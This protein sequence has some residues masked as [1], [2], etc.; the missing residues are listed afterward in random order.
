MTDYNDRILQDWMHF[1]LLPFIFVETRRGCIWGTYS[2][3]CSG[4]DSLS[5]YLTIILIVALPLVSQGYFFCPLH[6]SIMAPLMRKY[7]SSFFE[8]AKIK[9]CMKSAVLIANH[10]YVFTG[11]DRSNCWRM[12][13]QFSYGA[14]SLTYGSL[15]R[16]LRKQTP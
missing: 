12:P 5:F 8:L 6:C 15:S 7:N 2:Q 3:Y 4:S 1:P 13:F 16:Q 10:Y 14:V 9:D 11:F